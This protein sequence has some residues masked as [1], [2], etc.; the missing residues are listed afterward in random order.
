MRFRSEFVYGKDGN[1]AKVKELFATYKVDKQITIFPEYMTRDN[2]AM[3]ESITER[4]LGLV[5]VDADGRLD[6]HLPLLREKI[7][8][9]CTVILDDYKKNYGF[10][11]IS[12][13]YAQGKTK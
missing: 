8:M 6:I 7:P 5:M 2:Y 13:R 1:L 12:D 4:K 10:R 11:P 9:N 3:L